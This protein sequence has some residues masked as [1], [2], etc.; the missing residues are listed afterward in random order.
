MSATAGMAPQAAVIGGAALTERPELE[1]DV[2][3]ARLLA[4]VLQDLAVLHH[5]A[6]VEDEDRPFRDPFQPDH[7]LVEYPVVADHLLVEIAEQREGQ[8]LLVVDTLRRKA[9]I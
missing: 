6:P 2:V 9:R 1:E 7:V 8:P 5:A 3:V 4:G